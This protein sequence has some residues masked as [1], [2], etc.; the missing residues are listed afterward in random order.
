VSTNALL[1]RIERKGISIESYCLSYT[2]VLLIFLPCGSVPLV[3]TVRVLL[4]GDTTMRPLVVI[5]PPFLTFNP[6][7]RSSTFVYDRVSDRAGRLLMRALGVAGGMATG[8]SGSNLSSAGWRH[9]AVH[10]QVFHQLAVVIGDVP[11]R[12]GQSRE[13][14]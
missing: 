3:V 8:D 13:S 12:S 9:D 1:P 11:H 6:N 2:A 5:L 14:V 7:V 4:S 10:P